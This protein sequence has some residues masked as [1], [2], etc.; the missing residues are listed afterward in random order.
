MA[1]LFAGLHATCSI[2]INLFKECLTR[3]LSRYFTGDPCYTAY[4][5]LPVLSAV[6]ARPRFASAWVYSPVCSSALRFP[7]ITL[8]LQLVRPGPHLLFEGLLS[9][10][11][12]KR[13]LWQ[14]RLL[15]MLK[16]SRHA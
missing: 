9:G 12:P 4:E 8:P 15:L 13:L 3:P 7:E 1:A 2:F 16:M 6:P 5:A 10:R 14:K 11:L